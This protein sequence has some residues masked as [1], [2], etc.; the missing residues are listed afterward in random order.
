MPIQTV[1]IGLKVALSCD[2]I[3]IK[4]FEII[5]E[6]LKKANSQ[7]N[8]DFFNK[9]VLDYSLKI[10]SKFVIKEESIANYYITN[11]EQ[12][13]KTFREGIMSINQFSRESFCHTLS[14]LI[15]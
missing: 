3:D 15:E 13:N 9:V 11:E 12:L 6:N 8:M 4:I 7:E 1:C 5:T 2:L 10:F 14:L